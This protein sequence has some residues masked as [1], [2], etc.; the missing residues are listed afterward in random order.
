MKRRRFPSV[1]RVSAILLLTALI[2][3]QWWQRQPAGTIAVGCPPWPRCIV[4]P[5]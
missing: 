4:R 3:G 2:A 1:F 5:L